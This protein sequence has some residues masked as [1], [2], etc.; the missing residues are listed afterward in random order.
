MWRH[1]TSVYVRLAA[2]M[3]VYTN[4]LRW[5]RESVF[6]HRCVRTQAAT[7]TWLAYYDFTCVEIAT[8]VHAQRCE[9]KTLSLNDH[10]WRC[11][12]TWRLRHRR[13]WKVNGAA[14]GLYGKCNWMSSI[15][16][17]VVITYRSPKMFKLLWFLICCHLTTIWQLKGYIL[18]GTRHVQRLLHLTP[19]IYGSSNKRHGGIALA[20]NAYC[21]NFSA[22]YCA[23]TTEASAL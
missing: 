5:L 6:S 22:I 20:A 11:T 23:I 14:S 7:L 1:I 21:A 8:C 3:L 18:Q 19:I 2:S 4:V 17:N 13:I 16:G 10:I 9:K 15:S 12:P